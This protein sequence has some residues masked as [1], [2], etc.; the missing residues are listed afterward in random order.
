MA[1]FGVINGSKVVVLLNFFMAGL[2]MWFLGRELK[3]GQLTR[4]WCSLLY[5]M[6]GAFPAPL[7]AGH[8]QLAFALGWLPWSIAGMLWVINRSSLASV[9]LASLAQALFFFTC[10]LYY[11]I[12]AFFCLLILS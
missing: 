2:G 12:Y 8:I 5:M 1:I 3:F 7:N 11:Q 10:N 4:L 6:S 9:L